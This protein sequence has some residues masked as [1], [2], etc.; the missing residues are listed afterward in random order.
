MEGIAVFACPFC[1]CNKNAG[2]YRGTPSIKELG[3]ET[4]D[5]KTC[6]YCYGE[7]DYKKHLIEVHNIHEPKHMK[8]DGIDHTVNE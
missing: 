3:C 8:I 6:H 2:Q 5:N 4:C 1:K 7:E